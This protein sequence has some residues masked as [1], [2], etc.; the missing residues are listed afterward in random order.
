MSSTVVRA[1]VASDTGA[2]ISGRFDPMALGIGADG[3]TKVQRVMTVFRAA[4]V[5]S[6]RTR[7]RIGHTQR[8]G[9]R[10]ETASRCVGAQKVQSSTTEALRASRLS[11]SK[12]PLPSYAS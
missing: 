4:L 5:C 2:R 6:F 10:G 1:P 7:G 11:Y 12:R 8:G 9:R 3:L